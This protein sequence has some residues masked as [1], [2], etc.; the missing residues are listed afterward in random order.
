ML[1]HAQLALLFNLGDQAGTAHPALHTLMILC[2]SYTAICQ[3]CTPHTT[4]GRHRKTPTDLPTR[5]A[6]EVASASH[7]GPR[8][9]RHR[10]VSTLPFHRRLLR[11]DLYDSLH[12]TRH[13]QNIPEYFVKTHQPS[14]NHLH[15]PFQANHHGSVSSRGNQSLH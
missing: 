2:R 5:Q 3:S 10:H 4:K 7:R 11:R 15:R 8:L 9:N 14:I 6:Y 13:C 12:P 1:P